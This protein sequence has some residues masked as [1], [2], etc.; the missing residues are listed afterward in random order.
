MAGGIA[1]PSNTVTLP[2]GKTLVDPGTSG[3]AKNVYGLN[4]GGNY[5]V[6]VHNLPRALTT[7]LLAN[8][9]TD[10][11]KAPAVKVAHVLSTM[12]SGTKE[13]RDAIATLQQMLWYS[14]QYDPAKVKSLQDVTLGRLG[15]DD[16]KAIGNVIDLA[17]KTQQ[18][19]GE[20]LVTSANIGKA[21]NIIN[22]Y[23]G[24]PQPYNLPSPA[25]EDAALRTAA[26]HLMGKD[27]DA[28][29]MARF[30]A[31]S[32]QM[33]MAANKKVATANEI[34]AQQA[35]GQQVGELA[36]ALQTT[37]QGF[38]DRPDVAYPA[39]AP[40]SHGAPGAMHAQQVLADQTTAANTTAATA[41]ATS[42]AGV[43]ASANQLGV[44]AAPS[45]ST[46]A[47]DFLRQNDQAGVQSH[48]LSNVFDLLTQMTGRTLSGTNRN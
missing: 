15:P 13:G 47:E 18:P 42:K 10:L 38:G 4:A 16:T 23:T 7:M 39:Q 31:F 12:S 9:V 14:N 24:S 33:T 6:D 32:D 37:G 45:V 20:Y 19:L 25:E 36:G 48:D 22:G 41:L 35:N 44:Q 26:Q 43:D 46:A 17:G 29:E 2:G 5:T 30:R 40:G 27:P 1:P 34:A 28:S 3:G 21:T 8:G 11:A